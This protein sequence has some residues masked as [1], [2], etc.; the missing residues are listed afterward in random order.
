MIDRKSS[1]RKPNRPR[2]QPEPERE[3]DAPLEKS[4]VDG[5]QYAMITSALLI[6]DLLSASFEHD[7]GTGID[8]LNDF[9][10]E[11]LGIIIETTPYDT[12][13]FPVLA[14][15]DGSWAVT[16]HSTGYVVEGAEAYQRWVGTFFPGISYDTMNWS[17]IADKLLDRDNPDTLNE[18]STPLRGMPR[19]TA[20]FVRVI[21]A[22]SGSKGSTVASLLDGL[23]ISRSS[24]NNALA[25]GMR[26]GI[27]QRSTLEPFR[28][29][30]SD[31]L[32][33]HQRKLLDRVAIAVTE[34]D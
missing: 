21:T 31:Q 3:K 4:F 15:K 6:H 11:P 8:S 1:R 29:R 24:V 23:K 27:L 22:I 32:D 26:A 20:D 17:P 9:L 14:A 10:P 28:Y 2:K 34:I 25:G 7:H 18:A 19:L 5:D 33:P 13:S 12:E 16:Q 30:V